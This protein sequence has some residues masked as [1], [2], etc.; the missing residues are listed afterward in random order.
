MEKKKEANTGLCSSGM[1]ANN[2]K[3]P[4]LCISGLFTRSRFDALYRHGYTWLP[5]VIDF[6]EETFNVGKQSVLQVHFNAISYWKSKHICLSGKQTVKDE[7][8]LC[9][10]QRHGSRTRV[11]RKKLEFN[12]WLDFT[13]G[14]MQYI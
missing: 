13:D 9:T 7:G 1:R 10:P 3:H 6:M 14:Y 5:C 8:K 11:E 2:I 12:S 4:E